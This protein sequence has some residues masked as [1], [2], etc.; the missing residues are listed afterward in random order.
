M[1]KSLKV[2]LI[3]LG[4]LVLI[5]LGLNLF[6]SNNNLKESLE[7]IQESQEK[8]DNAMQAIA[9]SKAQLDSLQSHFNKFNSYVHDIQGRV[10]IMDLERRA[11]DQRFQVKKDSIN[12]RLKDLYK[13]IETT[14]NDLPPVEEFDSH[15]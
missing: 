7:K 2:I 3:V 11:K 1:D 4:T 15:H 10:E 6:G 12:Q 13:E 5:N 14:G 9:K 8:L